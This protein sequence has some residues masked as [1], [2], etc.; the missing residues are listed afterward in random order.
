MLFVWK[1][2]K[3]DEIKN[4]RIIEFGSRTDGDSIRNVFEKWGCKK[5]IGID[6]V[7]G[8][9]VDVVCN[10]E[11][12]LDTFQKNSFDIVLCFEMMEHIADWRKAISNIKNICKEKGI[13]F[14]TTRS[15][16]FPYHHAKNE[17]DFWRYEKSD[18]EDIFSDCNVLESEYDA[19][20][21]G[22]FVKVKKPES[23]VEKDISNICLYSI[24]DG[25]KRRTV[26][27]IDY[28]NK[29]AILTISRYKLQTLI[30]K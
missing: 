17:T 19:S 2:L 24:I 25:M 26:D 18:M 20:Q 13:I 22:I 5:Y 15:R 10:A 16:G 12:I 9:N 7:A 23:F 11:N 28:G 6:Y 27:E 3:V 1:N 21:P 8:K 30:W 14:I 29:H 4:K